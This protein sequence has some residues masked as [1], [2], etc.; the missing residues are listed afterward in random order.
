MGRTQKRGATDPLADE[1]RWYWQHSESDMGVQSS[2]GAFVDMA[3]S[4]IQPGGRSNGAERRAAAIASRLDRPAQRHREMRR[5]IQA[6]GAVD[7]LHVRVLHAAYGPVNWTRMADDVFGRGTGERLA[8]ALGA[9][10]I[11]VALLTERLARH[12]AD[13]A[14]CP[15]SVCV[16]GNR[17]DLAAFSPDGEALYRYAGTTMMVHDVRTWECDESLRQRALEAAGGP[18]T[19]VGADIVAASGRD[20]DY[21]ARVAGV[22]RR[23]RTSRQIL[24]TGKAT[25]D[26]RRVDPGM[27][28]VAL[29][30]RACPTSV[31]NT[32][33]KRARAAEAL[34]RVNA[35]RDEAVLLL[36]RAR[37]ALPPA[38]GRPRRAPADSQSDVA[39]VPPALRQRSRPVVAFE[40]FAVVVDHVAPA[41]ASAS[42]W[43]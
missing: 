16:D 37:V 10:H 19:D 28:L 12:I 23:S 9:E 39:V 7:P 38:E 1:L 43:M 41:Q 25:R 42:R 31:P 3:M 14:P 11:G 26:D 6:L 35:I 30:L 13:D 2:F 21:A 27:A 8:R 29:V 22:R 32:P 24:A 17:W 20:L 36:Q 4:G 15:E 18:R 33:A 40:A 34:R 5:R